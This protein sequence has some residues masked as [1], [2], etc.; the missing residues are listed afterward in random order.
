MKRDDLLTLTEAAYLIGVSQGR[1]SQLIGKKKLNPV[2]KEYEG[3]VRVFLDKG[4]VLAFKRKRDEF[5]NQP[6]TAQTA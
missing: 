1:V 4:E 6:A 2:R 5:R 3:S